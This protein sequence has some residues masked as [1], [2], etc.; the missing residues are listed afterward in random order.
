MNE[1]PEHPLRILVLTPTGNDA[2]NA[3]LVLQETGL[4]AE[5]CASLVD[6]CDKLTE[7]AGVLLIAEEAFT[8][9]ATDRLMRL[10]AEQPPWSD[11]P[12]VLITAGQDLTH[13]R[14]SSLDIVA[15]AG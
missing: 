9:N 1:K 5:V 2:L 6:V 8:P 11:I 10:L 13:A 12:L 15:P 7:G 4:E 3:A 14:L